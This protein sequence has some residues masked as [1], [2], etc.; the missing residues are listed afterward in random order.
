MKGK[1]KLILLPY[2]LLVP[3][4]IIIL[5]ISFLPGL[6]AVYLS[7]FDIRFFQFQDINFVGL[8]NY[9]RVLNDSYAVGSIILT[10]RFSL[11]LLAV[12][13][14]LGLFFALFSKQLGGKKGRILIGI[15][16]I[17]WVT[18]KIISSLLFRWLINPLPGGFYFS[19]FNYFGI[20]PTNLL[21]DPSSAFI[22]LIIVEIWIHIGFA[23]ITLYAGL[24]SIPSELEESARIDGA[25]YF[26]ELIYIVLPL[27]APS[28]LVC[29]SM[30]TLFFFNEVTA[31]IALTSGGPVY[32][33]TTLSYYI[34]EKGF[35][36]FQTSYGN[37]LSTILFLITLFLIYL[38]LRF[39]RRKEYET[40]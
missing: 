1:R 9:F 34:I 8:S 37:T 35:Q 4:T 21:I 6:Y 29:I 23:S 36:E 5:I 17:P 14:L 15:L 24:A 26:Q 25:N 27:L 31:I 38:Q 7:L 32:A 30:L 28:I 16:L 19:L 13:F 22:T 39:F 33:T 40:Q 20:R 3:P 11:T 10:L 18:S 12:T 2:L